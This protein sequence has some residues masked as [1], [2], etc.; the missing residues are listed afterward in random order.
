M[1]EIADLAQR[2]PIEIGGFIVR[3]NDWTA[4]DPKGLAKPE[5]AFPLPKAAA[6]KVATLGALRDYLKTNR[7]GLDLS[8][9]IAHIESPNRVSV[10]SALR[11]PARD[12]E[13]YITAEAHDMTDGFVGKYHSSEDFNI[14]LQVRFVD[15]DQR[16]A[17]LD[18][19]SSVKTEQSAA[20][21]DNGVTQTLEARHGAV[22][23]SH[24]TLPNP[25]T[26]TPFRTFR[27]IM[28][29]SSVFVLRA[30]AE[31][32]QLPS[33]ALLEADGGTWKLSAIQRIKDW[34]D[35]ELKDL[36]IAVLA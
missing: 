20:A 17:L 1:T 33:L 29:P 16:A 15:M 7:D 19:V 21:L 24:Q 36:N 30:K 4:E 28:Q 14:G 3:P 22:L 13:I 12:R 35:T 23:K 26:L 34:L 10:G 9:L 6:L 18:V 32:G 11:A 8:K 31:Q 5:P 27:D 25:V 2:K